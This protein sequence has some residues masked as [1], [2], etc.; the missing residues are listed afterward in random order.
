MFARP[1]ELMLLDPVDPA[2]PDARTAAAN[3]HVLS[4]TRD[5]RGR[6]IR[7]I[8]LDPGELVDIP[9]ANIYLGNS[10]AIVPGGTPQDE[11]VRAR[12]SAVFPD[13]EIVQVPAR[14]LHE[15]GGGPHC[16]T[17]QVP[18]AVIS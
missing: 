2:D 13:R 11:V 14:T 7:V 9:Y 10:V 3:K 8:S 6:T 17:Q 18:A 1:G 16:I 4:G 15:G 12:V 5:A